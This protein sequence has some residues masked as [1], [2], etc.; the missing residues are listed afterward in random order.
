MHIL[1]KNNVSELII[2]DTLYIRKGIYIFV[3]R[4]HSKFASQFKNWYKHKTD[5]YLGGGVVVC[6]TDKKFIINNTCNKYFSLL[7]FEIT[8]IF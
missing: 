3:T 5:V 6:K 2:E 7:I 8:F 1:F 4:L